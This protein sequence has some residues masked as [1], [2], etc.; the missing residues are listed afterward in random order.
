MDT[1][2]FGGVVHACKHFT[3][4]VEIEWELA[5]LSPG[6]AELQL[7]WASS[8]LLLRSSLGWSQRGQGHDSQ[9]RC[10]AANELAQLGWMMPKKMLGMV[11]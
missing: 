5:F 4:I 2:H 11:Q 9:L 7:P 3:C 1:S 10:G 8:G 6:V